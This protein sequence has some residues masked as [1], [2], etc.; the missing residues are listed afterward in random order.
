MTAIQTGII[1]QIFELKWVTHPA[2]PRQ[3]F[4]LKF[5]SVVGFFC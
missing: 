4:P 1:L 5:Q 3:H 2:E